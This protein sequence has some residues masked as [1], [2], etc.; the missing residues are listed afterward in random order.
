MFQFR[1]V[2][3][4]IGSVGTVPH[5]LADAVHHMR[6][7][8]ELDVQLWHLI[9]GGTVGTSM[10]SIWSPTISAV[11]DLIDDLRGDRVF[12]DLRDETAVALHGPE[13]DS[14]ERVLGGHVG[15]LHSRPGS[16]QVRHDATGARRAG[17]WVTDPI[18]AAIDIG[19]DMVAVNDVY[20]DDRRLAWIR[21]APSH[22]ALA[23]ADGRLAGDPVWTAADA[24]A[25][26]HLTPAGR[27]VTLWRR[28]V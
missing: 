23:D 2:A 13:R 24:A 16:L 3:T 11:T 4:H 22:A 21:T 14:V 28:S 6:D 19:I 8:G 15:H 7:V 9:A 10:V 1:R 17:S 25:E 12:R 18:D 27:S 26:R 5:V 20:G